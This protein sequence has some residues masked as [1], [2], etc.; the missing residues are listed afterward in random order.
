[1]RRR[2]QSLL[3]SHA[4]A[5]REDADVALELALMPSQQR[6]S[7]LSDDSSF[8]KLLDKVEGESSKQSRNILLNLLFPDRYERIASRTHKQL[9]AETFSD[10]LD[11]KKM[12]EDLDERIY[13][14]RS[15]LEELLKKQELDFYWP[16]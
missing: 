16:P 13:A 9:I 4:A 2:R 14:I 15:R 3:S 7:V 5:A 10:I 8:R 12:P 1:V 6:Q 11:P